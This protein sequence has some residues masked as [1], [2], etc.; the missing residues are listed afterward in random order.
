[1]RKGNLFSFLQLL[2]VI[3]F[4]KQNQNWEETMH[5]GENLGRNLTPWRKTRERRA[6][7][8]ENVEWHGYMVEHLLVYFLNSLSTYH[9]KRYLN[10]NRALYIFS[11]SNTFFTCAH[12]RYRVSPALHLFLARN[13]EQKMYI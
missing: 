5:C 8:I 9:L 1:M 13:P 12:S 4:F 10:K 6:D 2:P 11:L 3:W 7:W